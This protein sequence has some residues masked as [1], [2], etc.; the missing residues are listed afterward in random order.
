[1]AKKDKGKGKGKVPK[2]IAGMK[3]P[4]ALR[5]GLASSLLDNPRTREILADVLM[6]AAGAAAAAL[7]KNRPSGQQVAEAGE[8][9]M[10]AGAGAATTARHILQSSA[11]PVTEVVADAARQILPSS[12][13]AMGDE[14]S[15]DKA[16]DFAH[17]VG[18]GRKDKKDK[19][20]SRASKH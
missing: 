16:E 8:A 12:L 5:K 10:D 7:V 15:G 6:A 3:V 2:T 13:M 4:K 20:R 1:V 17:P 18:E 9:V 14:D 11:G 19:Q